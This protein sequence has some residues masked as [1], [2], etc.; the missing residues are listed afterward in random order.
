MRVS[1]K[2]L[3]EFVEIDISPQELADRLTLAGITVEGITEPGAGIEKVITGRIESIEPHP[4][5]DKL[6]VTRVNTGA[7]QL[8]IITA[9]TNVR[10]GDIIPVAVEGPAGQRA[11]YQTRLN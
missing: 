5:A 2:W 4:N 11:G 9:A 8:Q 7:E 1:Y 6:V 3:Q 10:E